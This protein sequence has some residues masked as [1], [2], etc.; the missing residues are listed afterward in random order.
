MDF[1]KKLKIFNVKP[2]GTRV[3]DLSYTFI[4]NKRRQSSEHLLNSYNISSCQCAHNEGVCWA[5]IIAPIIFNSG[6]MPGMCSA[7][8][9]G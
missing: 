5:L 9:A 6:F 7:S 4:F 2:S 1:V 8:C 3:L